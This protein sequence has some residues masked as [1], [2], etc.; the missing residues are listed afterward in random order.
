[1][2]GVLSRALAIRCAE[3]EAEYARAR[4][5]IQWGWPIAIT[6]GLRAPL[7]QVAN[8]MQATIDDGATSDDLAILCAAQAHDV[9]QSKPSDEQAQCDYGHTLYQLS[10]QL[11]KPAFYPTG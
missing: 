9:F 2:N 3:L 5:Q 4:E 6:P 8:E 11:Y 10:Q 1:M 7:Q